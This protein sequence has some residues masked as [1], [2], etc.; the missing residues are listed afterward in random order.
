M[1]IL[2]WRQRQAPEFPGLPRNRWALAALAV[3]MLALTITVTPFQI[4]GK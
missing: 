4:T 1:N 2:T 3:I